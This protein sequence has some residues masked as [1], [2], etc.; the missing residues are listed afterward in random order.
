MRKIGSEKILEEKH[1]RSVT[2]ISVFMLAVLIIGTAGYAFTSSSGDSDEGA[3]TNIRDLGGRWAV[4]IGGQTFTF[5]S[6]PDDAKNISIDKT[7]L[8]KDYV[9]KPIY[10]D[11]KNPAI[12]AE[13][14]STLSRFNPRVQKACFGSCPDEDLPE[15]DCSENLIVWQD[16]E[17]NKIYKQDKC[18]FIQGDLRAVDAF[19]YYILEYNN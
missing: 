2:I 5:N 1:K 3:D 18:V 8:P 11:S 7:I 15:K 10:I 16:G 19:L 6:H 13:L 12:F 14:Y 9:G 4:D 17:E